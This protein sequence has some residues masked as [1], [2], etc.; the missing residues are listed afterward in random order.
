VRLAFDSRPLVNLD[1]ERCLLLSSGGDGHRVRDIDV[2]NE[3]TKKKFEAFRPDEL[4][5]RVVFR[6]GDREGCFFWEEMACREVLVDRGFW[7]EP[8]ARITSEDLRRI[9]QEFAREIGREVTLELSNLTG[10]ERY[11]P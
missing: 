5:G 10:E 8:E 3:Q 6:E 7:L 11:Y 4:A 1:V 9:A 2:N